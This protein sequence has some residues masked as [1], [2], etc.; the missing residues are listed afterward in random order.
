MKKL[1]SILLSV[2][3]VSCMGISVFASNSNISPTPIHGDIADL[4]K[5]E[6]LESYRVALLAKANEPA[7]ASIYNTAVSWTVNCVCDNEW[8]D[9]LNSTGIGGLD[10]AE[11]IID[12]ISEK[13]EEWGSIALRGYAIKRSLNSTSSDYVVHLNEARDNYGVGSR[14]MMMAFSG[15]Q[16]DTVNV[17][18]GAYIGDPYSIMFLT[19][20]DNTWKVGRHEMGHMFGVYGTDADSDC[21]N[22][23]MMNDAC[24][25]QERYD[26]IC[27]SCKSLLVANRN[28]LSTYTYPY[29]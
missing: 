16:S 11:F 2:C 26:K 9:E 4:T 10:A 24:L 29:E 19:S 8:V 22:E 18:G 7:R 12:E 21:V 28:Y 17:V 14:D 3:M 15:I 23:C 6:I 25:E 13:F 5:E 20:Y 27:S 1:L